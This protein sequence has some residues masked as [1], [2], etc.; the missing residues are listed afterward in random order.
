MKNVEKR[1]MKK[2][3]GLGFGLI[4]AGMILAFCAIQARAQSVVANVNY[5]GTNNRIVSGLDL[6]GLDLN[7]LTTVDRSTDVLLSVRHQGT[8]TNNKNNFSVDSKY[9]EVAGNIRIPRFNHYVIAGAALTR[10]DMERTTNYRDLPT[11]LETRTQIVVPVVGL[12]GWQR[13]GDAVFNYSWRLYPRGSRTE[14][15]SLGS[16]SHKWSQNPSTGNELRGSV[17]HMLRPPFGLTDLSGNQP[18]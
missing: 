12:V 10:L 4:V 13:L 17:T 7:I 18:L 3:L 1:G 11:Q 6:N 2:L 16:E 9:Y 5:A 8:S 14:S 15:E